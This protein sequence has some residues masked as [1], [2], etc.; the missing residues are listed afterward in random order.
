MM[1]VE[2]AAEDRMESIG[3]LP[4]RHWNVKGPSP[5]TEI[6]NEAV[7]AGQVENDSG[8]DE[9]SR[10]GVIE[11][12]QLSIPPVAELRNEAPLPPFPSRDGCRS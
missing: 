9:T 8:C 6:E 10:H 3:T 1:S 2:I 12:L 4:L 11:T 7:L 5:A